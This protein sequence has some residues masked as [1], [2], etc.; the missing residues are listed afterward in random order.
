MTNPRCDVK[1]K[2][3][4][5]ISL[6]AS[7]VLGGLKAAPAYAENPNPIV[8]SEMEESILERMER[9][10]TLDVRDMNI[11]D[12]IKFLA[13]KGEF[14][15]VISP[16][17]EGRST[18][19]LNSVSIKDALDIVIISNHLAY[20]IQS[21]IVQIMSSAEYEAMFG[22]KFGDQTDVKIVRLQYSKPNYVLSAL[23]NIKSNVGKIIIDEDTGSVVMIDTP[24][25]I[26]K[27][28]EALKEIEKP[29]ETFV[30]TLQYAKADDVAGK[31]RARI[32]AKSV[33][34]VTPDDRS[35]KI[36]VRAFPERIKEVEEIIKKLDTP[37]K[38]VLVDARILQVVL[39]PEYD[40]GIDWQL[41]FR[42]SS[43]ENIKKLSFNNTFMDTDNIAASDNLASTFGQVAVGNFNT[44][45]FELKIRALEK[46]SDTKILSNPKILVTN[47]EEAKI[48]IG[49]TVPY[50]ISTTSGTGDSAI[51]SEDVRFVDVGLKL[52]VKPIIN[53]EE[54]VSMHLRPEIST[55]VGSITSQGGGIP[56][57]NKTQVE[58]TVLVKNGNTI[59]MGGLKKDDK[60]HTKK[61]FPVLMDLPV[62]G[63]I[64]GRTHDS[65]SQTEIVIFI[66]P[67]IVT[68]VDG[69]SKVEGTIKP[70]KSYSTE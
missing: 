21:N 31:L 24:E 47:G 51:T 5:L 40:M 4:I 18:V 42:D 1:K 62:V 33:G 48:H 38:E 16:M 28:E 27:M 66:T 34:A 61:G 43:D 26:A 29:L 70:F 3:Y 20:K 8:I 45:A 58:T 14:N 17:V 36:I 13:L 63:S 52:N 65:F 60:V 49:D 6:A 39:K 67:H 9:L 56:Q 2:I 53:D 12:V 15:V 57:V 10:I 41:D 69:Y 7:V 19:L 37:T 55:V 23:D 22:K 54:F 44:D 68:G 30:Y 32:D 50:I 11:V 25:T 46:V 64:F 59:I 35:N